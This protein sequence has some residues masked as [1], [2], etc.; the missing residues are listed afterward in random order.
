PKSAAALI[1]P[2]SLPPIVKQAAAIPTS[3]LI[4]D[5]RL[6]L[7]P[8]TCFSSRPPISARS[9]PASHLRQRRSPPGLHQRR[10]PPG[11]RQRRSPPASHLRQHRPP[12][13]SHLRQRR[14]PPDSHLRQVSASP[15]PL[16]RRGSSSLSLSGK[17]FSFFL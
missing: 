7:I 17:L 10:S 14:S 2:N 16:L 15:L 9:L 5:L 6:L 1:F 12:P 11:L 4:A 13:A 3:H 8:A